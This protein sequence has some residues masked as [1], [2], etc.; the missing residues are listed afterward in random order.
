MDCLDFWFFMIVT[1]IFK[2]QQKSGYNLKSVLDKLQIK[3]VYALVATTLVS[4]FGEK[5]LFYEVL[6][7]LV[8]IDTILGVLKASKRNEISS[9]KA[10]GVVYK[11]FL[12][13]L[14]IIA[15]HQIIRL[16]SSLMILEQFV[17]LFLA[18]TELLSIVENLNIL[19]VPIPESF[20]KKIRGYLKTKM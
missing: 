16:E 11:L 18:C 10:K 3:A 7:I 6:F 19:G 17:V 1:Y 20:S 15:T 5:T 13:Y 9:N 12:Y 14:L 2:Q 8:I 4:L